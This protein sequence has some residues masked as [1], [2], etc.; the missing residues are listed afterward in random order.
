[1][2]RSIRPIAIVVAA[3]LA[4]G[5]ALPTTGKR[6]ATGATAETVLKGPKING[7]Q[8]PDAACVESR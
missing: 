2:T 8:R 7:G 6:G 1:M 5:C 4:A 3:C